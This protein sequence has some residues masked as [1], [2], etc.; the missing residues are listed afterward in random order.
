MKNVGSNMRVM[1]YG[2]ERITQRLTVS[3]ARTGIEVVGT[4]DESRV[5]GMLIRER[6]GLAVVDSLME[7]AQSTCR[8]IRQLCDTRVVALIGREQKNWEHADLLECDG[9][10]CEGMG[11]I[12]IAARLKAVMRFRAS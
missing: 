3:L 12:E 1:V 6:C 2:S 9:F 5:I 4:S 10:V 7:E 8:C 11:P